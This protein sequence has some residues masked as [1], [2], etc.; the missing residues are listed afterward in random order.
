[1]F[2]GFRL[3]SIIILLLRARFQRKAG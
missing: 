3:I 1:M 2:I